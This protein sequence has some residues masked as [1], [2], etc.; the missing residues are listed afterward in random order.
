MRYA[1]LNTYI[2][3][4][5]GTGPFA[6]EA[7]W[8]HKTNGRTFAWDDAELPDS[9]AGKSAYVPKEIEDRLAGWFNTATLNNSAES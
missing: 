2:H 5:Q 4:A 9:K 8:F 1:L 6:P 3:K 7:K